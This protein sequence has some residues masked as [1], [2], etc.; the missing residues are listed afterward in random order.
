MKLDWLSHCFDWNPQ[1]FRECKG[2]L[3]RRNLM[4]TISG[5]VLAQFAVLLYFWGEIPTR[6][7]SSSRYCTGKFIYS[8]NHECVNTAGQPLEQVRASL[9][10]NSTEFINF[11]PVILWQHWWTDLF[12]TVSWAIPFILL[13]AG[14]YMLIADLAKEERRGTLNFIRLSPQTSRSILIGKMLGVPILPHLGVALAIPLHLWSAIAAGIPIPAVLSIYALTA[15]T[16]AFFY[17][18]ACLFSF[19]GGS[20]PWI[21][22]LLVWFSLSIIFPITQQ[23]LYYSSGFERF[24]LQWFYVEILPNLNLL[25]PFVL[26]VLGIGT[27]WIWQALNRRFRNPNATL[28][29]KQQSYAMTAC[30]EVLMLGFCIRTSSSGWPSPIDELGIWAFLNL[31][32]F[33]LLIAALTPHRQTLLDWA[34][35]RRDRNPTAKTIWQRSIVKDLVWGEKSPALVAIALNLL[36]GIA[37]CL[38]WIASWS[39]L[40]HQFRSVVTLGL[41]ALFV[42]ICAAIAQLFLFT[43]SPRRSGWATSAILALIGLPPLVLM[44][45]SLYPAHA[46][47]LWLFTAFAFSA[48]DR[49]SVMAVFF[50]FLGHLSVLSLL[51]MRLSRQLQKA[52][53]SESYALL[54]AGSAS[55]LASH[56]RDR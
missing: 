6:V 31:C 38:L 49:V 12:Q 36:I 52:G 50:S 18:G 55:Q 11:Q 25:I 30:I 45:T 41:G 22:A 44:F 29:S 46:P 21:G 10:I 4:L 24:P 20:Q 7:T 17:T 26:V 1:F 14:V 2:R 9:G 8:G 34:R 43:K 47:D 54:S 33:L 3:K 5:S 56:P 28:V 48:L 40:H 37:V 19:M 42:L 27:Y 32:W 35:Y 15:V 53:A 51:T 13:M 16:C 39:N 23:L